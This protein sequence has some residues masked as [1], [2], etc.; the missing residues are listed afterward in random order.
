[1]GLVDDMNRLEKALSILN[2][3][4]DAE[5]INSAVKRTLEKNGIGYFLKDESDES[6]RDMPSFVIECGEKMIGLETTEQKNIPLFARKM[7]RY[8]HIDGVIVLGPKYLPGMFS[9][10][11]NGMP[12]LVVNTLQKKACVQAI[13]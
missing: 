5:E 3:I 11:I 10:G 8:N 2:G 1:M 7:A 6:D 13:P 9:K 4:A 12:V